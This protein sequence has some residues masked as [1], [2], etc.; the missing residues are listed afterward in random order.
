MSMALVIAALGLLNVMLTA[1]PAAAH[2]ELASSDPQNV[3][4]VAG[5]LSVVRLTYSA[6]ADPV[7]D[8]FTL[9]DA[10]DAE[11]RIASVEKESSTVLVVRTSDPLPIGR[12]R[13][14]WAIRSGDS[15]TMTGSV[16]FTVIEPT[17]SGDV[18]LPV[19]E[20][21]ATD[22]ADTSS[23]TPGRGASDHLATVS[24]WAV[25]GAAFLCVGGLAYLAWVHR[26]TE[27]EGRRAVFYVRRAAV[28][29]IIAAVVE[30]L[31]QLVVAR[32]GDVWAV[33]SVSTWRDQLGTGFATG[34]ALRLVGAALVLAFLRIDHAQHEE[35]R[36]WGT[37]LEPD[38][39]P[40]QVERPGGGVGVVTRPGAR[41]MRLRVEASPVA[42]IGAAALVVSEAFIGHTATVDPRFVVLVADA[43]HLLGGAA[44]VAG[45]LMLVLTLHRRHRRRQPLDARILATRYAVMATWALV[46]VTVTGVALSWSILREPSALW[47]TEFGRLLL[48][49]L[50]V[51]AVVVA[52]GAH[53]HRVLVPTLAEGDDAAA[54]RFRRFLSAEVALFGTILLLTALLV[55]ANPT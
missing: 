42:F 23:V 9:R 51:V 6:A 16:S 29:V 3:S 10:S 36:F 27:D 15:H 28:I 2:V 33:L 46:A 8:Q 21:S 26:G 48:A 24:R 1:T 37:D 32:S 55:V 45:G 50:A 35:H 31:T 47:A 13:L 34:T 5:P 44:W 17:G 54:H 49:K 38:G 11:V 20:P 14:S 53:N 52:I 25:Y 30:W 18:A 4:T 40:D 22:R 43:G 7:S 19:A 39:G 41:L 12:A